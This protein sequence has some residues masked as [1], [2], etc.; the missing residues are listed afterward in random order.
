M[1]E[2]LEKDSGKIEEKD[3]L[4]YIKQEYKESLK[5]ALDI[6]NIYK[7]EM[8]AYK[9]SYIGN[10]VR[11]ELKNYVNSGY[12]KIKKSVKTLTLKSISSE[13]QGDESTQNTYKLIAKVKEFLNL[14]D[15]KLLD[16]DTIFHTF[17]KSG[18]DRTGV[19]EIQTS[20]EAILTY[21]NKDDIANDIAQQLVYGGHTQIIPSINAGTPGSH[22]L[23]T[24]VSDTFHAGDPFYKLGEKSSKQNH[25]KHKSTSDTKEDIV[26]VDLD[27]GYNSNTRLAFIN[28]VFDNHWYDDI[29]IQNILRAE[30]GINGTDFSNISVMTENIIRF[31]GEVDYSEINIAALQNIIRQDNAQGE[32]MFVVNNSANHWVGVRLNVSEN[33]NVTVTV[34]DSIG[35][36]VDSTLSGNLSALITSVFGAIDTMVTGATNALRQTNGNDCGP[37]TVANLVSSV[38]KNEDRSMNSQEIR[39][40]HRDILNNTATEELCEENT[41]GQG[42]NSCND[43]EREGDNDV[44][45]VLNIEIVET[46][47][48]QPDTN[49]E[50][51]GINYGINIFF[52]DL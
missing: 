49:L 46:Q 33:K 13:N 36:T 1:V 41:V 34:Y 11:P 9:E 21:L 45:F 23:I 16:D 20:Y 38:T 25:L 8:C 40:H 30:V 4:D 43:S 39:E 18:K 51:T 32:Y 3:Y 6:H 31:G 26:M 50:D 10:L 17:C 52:S 37:L 27:V 44:S 28:E 35:S 47:Y 14:E 12:D 24:Q 7:G 2:S 22:G 48:V 19:G 15:N 42:F 5:L 29:E